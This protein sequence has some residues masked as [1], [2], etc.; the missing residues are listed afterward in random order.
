MALGHASDGFYTSGLSEREARSR[1]TQAEQ[2]ESD[3][4]RTRGRGLK[5]STGLVNAADAVR[6][7]TIRF[8]TLTYGSVP[9]ALDWRDFGVI[10]PVLDQGACGSSWAIATA[11]AVESANALATGN[12]VELRYSCD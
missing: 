8:A 1:N 2:Q 5:Y 12:L 10:G 6:S 4:E 9:P 11:A 3:D 7:S